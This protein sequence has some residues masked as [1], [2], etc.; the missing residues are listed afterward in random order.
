MREFLLI[1]NCLIAQMFQLVCVPELDPRMV[2]MEQAKL[3]KG[4]DQFALTLILKR[5]TIWLLET[6]CVTLLLSFLLMIL[7]WVEETGPFVSRL[8]L[9]HDMLIAL[10]MAAI[11]MVNT[12][13]VL[14][15]AVSRIVWRSHS[16][17]AYP[18]VAAVL[19]LAHLQYL[20]REASGQSSSERLAIR[21]GGACVVVACTLVGSWL[22][23]KWA[24]RD[25]KKADAMAGR[26]SS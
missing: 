4:V 6:A 16:F 14:T 9:A 7:A 13:Y 11:F 19:F 1:Q 15:T 12:G 10:A 22:L 8:G 20:F 17:W 26:G 3:Q 2:D 24:G 5:L 23:R 25:S 21:V 18:A